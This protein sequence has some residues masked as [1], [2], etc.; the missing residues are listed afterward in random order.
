[1]NLTQNNL[2]SSAQRVQPATV[3]P[4]DWPAQRLQMDCRRTL[5]NHW[6]AVQTL[7]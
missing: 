6:K 1:M 5:A 4:L 7:P 3:M 2:S